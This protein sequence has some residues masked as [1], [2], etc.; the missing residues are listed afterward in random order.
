[1]DEHLTKPLDRQRLQLTLERFLPA[2][3]AAGRTGARG[4]G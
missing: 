4:A 2:G 3:E 1:M